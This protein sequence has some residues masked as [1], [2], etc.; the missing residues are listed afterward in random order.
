MT[1]LPYP[2]CSLLTLYKMP[3]YLGRG[4]YSQMV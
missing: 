2:V 4:D 1:D 3:G